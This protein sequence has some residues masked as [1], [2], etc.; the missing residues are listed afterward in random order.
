MIRPAIIN[1][2]LFATLPFAICLLMS[3][4]A[5]VIDI[6]EPKFPNQTFDITD[7]GAVGDGQSKNTDAFA[8]AVEACTQAGGGRVNVPAGVWLTG[9]IELASNLDLHL[10]TGAVIL[11]SSDFED[12]P[13]VRKNY[14]GSERLRCQSPI[15]GTDLENIAITG[16]GVIDGSG[17]AW[18][19]V[20]KIKMTT[21]QWQALIESGGVL[22][23]DQD[24]WWPNEAALHGQ[25]TLEELRRLNAPLSDYASVR[26]YLRPV[27][28]SLVRC[29][30][31][32]LHG[33]TFQNSPGWN[34]HPLLCEN[35]TVRDITVRNPW[36]SQNGDGLDIDSCRNVLL[37][38]SRFDVGDDAICL[39]SGKDEAGRK[40]GVPTENV[41][42][43]DCTV[44]HG[45]GGVTVGS[46]M[47]GGVRNVTVK[48]CT[49]LGTDIGLRFKS[50]RGRGGVV[51]N[52]TIENV[53]MVDI[54]KDAIRFNLFYQGN[55]LVP[56]DGAYDKVMEPVAEPVDEGTPCFRKIR[57]KDL[58]CRGAGRAAWLQGLPE[59]PI[60]EVILENVKIIADEGV[61]CVDAEQLTF[62]NVTV[63]CQ[64]GYGFWLFNSRN[65][66][67][68]DVKT[69]V[70]ADRAI[71]LS[72]SKTEAILYNGEG[73]N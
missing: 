11:F 51:E 8:A 30:N 54:V 36:Y 9:P 43:T 67:L 50:T 29:K 25:A 1:K 44:Y 60:Q 58:V 46:E 27:M 34:I 15:H 6:P 56:V 32:L 66:I 68:D 28:V 73:L 69:R 61:A 38:N 20:K 26:A 2:P 35:L 64:S 13:V 24:I 40:R 47:S 49:F 31:V 39:K 41:T 12:Y 70:P 3:C 16:D 10:E 53:R 72:G 17:Q 37:T 65:V 59:M 45:H 23:A 22:N 4:N 55:T 19:P 14:E 63:E 5:G 7:Y 48:N 33:P 62:K 21:P 18:R 71:K 42:I 52:I 57:I